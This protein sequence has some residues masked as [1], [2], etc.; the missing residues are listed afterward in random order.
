[1]ETDRQKLKGNVIGVI[2]DKDFRSFF[3]RT[4]TYMSKRTIGDTEGDKR[5]IKVKH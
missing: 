4:V 2:V 5:I 1:M 3:L